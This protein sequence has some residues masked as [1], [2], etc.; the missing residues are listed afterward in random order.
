MEEKS[1]SIPSAVPAAGVLHADDHCQMIPVAATDP[2]LGATELSH[3]ITDA[4]GV[5][6][7]AEI[8][9]GGERVDRRFVTAA[10][11]LVMVLASM[12][13]TVTSTAM[14]TIIGELHGLEHYSWVATMYLLAAT[15]SM[16]ML[17]RLADVLGRKKVIVGSIGLFSISSLLASTSHSM[18]ELI[19]FRG[20]QGVGAGGIMPIV[21]TIMGDLFTLEQRARIQGLFS[22]V[23]GTASL[24]GPA[25]GAFLVKTLGWRSVFYVN[26]PAGMLG[27]V[28]L[29]WKYRDV[30]RPV[31]V[32]LDIPGAA[33]L[34]AACAMILLI[35]SAPSGQFS[36][37]TMTGMC[38]VIAGLIA[39]LIRHEQLTANPILPPHL[40]IHRSI[41]PSLIASALLGMGFL[42]LDTYVPLYV[43]GGRGGD[44]TAAGLVVT[45]VMLTWALSGI[46][47][48][49]MVVRYGFRR[50][51]LVGTTLVTIGFTGLVICALTS[52]PQWILTAVL[53][54][55]GLGFG[56]ASMSYLLAAQDVTTWEYRGI[57]T[58]SVQFFRTMGGAVGVGILGGLLN[59]FMSRDMQQLREMGLTPS[60]LL[61]PRTLA[62]LA[63][64]HLHQVQQMIVG[65]SVILFMTMVA[66]A[67]AGIIVSSRMSLRS[68]RHER[69]HIDAMEA[70]AG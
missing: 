22:A 30:Q 54:I 50:T 56:P 10:L 36:A 64:D 70:V 18:G 38:I 51:A 35:V 25:L 19:L 33:A 4:D 20:L 6:L 57:I 45:S 9:S 7:P 47:A 68:V 53:A 42:S 29:V 8:L 63:P 26:L 43:Q 67:V 12:E 17:G 40:L 13:Q 69:Q 34:A 15:V 37:A 14:P 27:L 1:R 44:A 32:S 5:N 31:K 48:A 11:M 39:F 59:R 3:P 46:V 16:P 61:D 65:G 41:G 58:S 49:P 52:A 21:L 66:F 24:A 23:W 62:R 60:A 28:V 2:K 55:T